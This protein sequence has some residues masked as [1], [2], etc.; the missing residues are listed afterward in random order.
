MK[1][2]WFVSSL[3]QKGGGERF[4]LEGVAAL[5]AFG[6]EAHVACDRIDA[7]ASFDGRYDLADVHCTAQHFSRQAGYIA[8]AFN[9]LR[10]VWALSRVIRRL[11]PELVICQSEFDAIKLY[12]LSRVLQFRYRVFVFGQMYQFKTDLT[13]YSSVFRRH[14]E[15]VIASRPGYRDTVAMPPPRL[16]LLVMAINEVVSR[17]KYRA[18]RA[19][20]SVF[21]VSSQVKWEVALVYGRDATVCRAAFDERFI[22]VSAVTAPRPVGQPMRLLSVSRL[23]DKKRIDLTIAALSLAKAPLVMTIIGRGPEEAR[24][25]ELAARSA[26][27]ADIVFLG[28]VDDATLQAELARADCLISMDIGDYDI[29]VV[30]A[31][32]K[33]LRVVVADDFDMAGFGAPFGGIVSV[34]PDAA[35]LASAIDGIAAMRPPGPANLPVLRRLTWQSLALTCVAEAP[36]LALQEPELEVGR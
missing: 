23:V 6:H 21:T 29:S 27:R 30:E 9:K 35:T 33:G 12:L 34:H 32:G 36:Q 4:V 25:R 15:A 5:R 16:P 14:L 17:L 1:V 7:A 22:D 2:L 19:A 28:A 18:L 20:D 3:E 26:R 31:M 11:G 13:R 8:R 10:G 24:L